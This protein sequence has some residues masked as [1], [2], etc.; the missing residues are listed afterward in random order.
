MS[1]YLKNKNIQYSYKKIMP[2][3]VSQ[4][5]LNSSI[6]L[7]PSFPVSVFPPLCL[8]IS[9]LNSLSLIMFLKQLQEYSAAEVPPASYCGCPEHMFW[10][11]AHW[12]RH[13]Y[14]VFRLEWNPACRCQATAHY[15][16]KLNI[17]FHNM[18]E[19]VWPLAVRRE[20]KVRNFLRYHFCSTP[21]YF[22]STVTSCCNN[23]LCTSYQYSCQNI[24]C[25][26]M[27][28]SAQLS[29]EKHWLCALQFHLDTDTDGKKDLLLSLR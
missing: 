26:V 15:Q 4:L 25:T 20:W 11:T 22:P 29:P 18:G 24:C 16:A 21:L 14:K 19:Q 5:F 13:I 1:K 9:P 2:R 6:P 8:I 10:L 3:E 27:M 7:S 17:S 12:L 28:W 23:Y